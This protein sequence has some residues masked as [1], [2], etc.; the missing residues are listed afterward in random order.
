MSANPTFS[1]P[2]AALWTLNASGK[3]HQFMKKYLL[4]PILGLALVLLLG[5][6]ACRT[7]TL[8]ECLCSR[9]EP[10]FTASLDTINRQWTD[11]QAGQVQIVWLDARTSRVVDTLFAFLSPRATRARTF[12]VPHPIFVDEGSSRP[13]VENS[14]FILLQRAMKL[15]DTLD[16][17]TYQAISERRLCNR[18]SS[19]PDHYVDCM[20]ATRASLRHN[21]QPLQLQRE[22]K[23]SLTIFR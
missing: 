18:C 6:S 3:K 12:F 1:L 9:G 10:I 4:F 22:S 16:N 8:K 7:C 23:F 13:L 19:G 20:E 15:S 5:T 21:N 17:I 2:N 11:E 14:R